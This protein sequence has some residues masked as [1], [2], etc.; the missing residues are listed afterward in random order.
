MIHPTIGAPERAKKLLVEAMTD[1]VTDLFSDASVRDLVALKIATNR[2]RAE[3]YEQVIRPGDPDPATS[4]RARQSAAC[5]VGI[6]SGPPDY[7]RGGVTLGA[8][9]VYYPS[10]V[11][12][13]DGSLGMWAS[14]IRRRKK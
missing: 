10:F 9:Q 4:A 6:V 13:S 1:V 14:Q 11:D 7:A 8:G 2:S 12:K 3:G 5:P